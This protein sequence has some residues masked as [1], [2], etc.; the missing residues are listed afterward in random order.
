[1]RKPRGV[2][3]CCVDSSVLTGD[4]GGPSDVQQP[5]GPPG[6]PSAS[7]TVLVQR[8]RDKGDVGVNG[9]SARPPGLED[10]ARPVVSTGTY[11]CHLC[12]GGAALVA[13]RGSVLVAPDTP[14]SR[15]PT[16]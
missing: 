7:S 15:E 6:D 1:M 9:N 8:E 16:G 11:C 2:E 13:P 5:C 14:R 4:S 3:A 12:G 10:D